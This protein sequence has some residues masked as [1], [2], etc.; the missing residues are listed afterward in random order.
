MFHDIKSYEARQMLM[1]Y[2]ANLDDFGAIAKQIWVMAHDSRAIDIGHEMEMIAHNCYK[3]AWQ[4]K[5]TFAR[6]HSC[7]R[8]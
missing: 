6:S 2:L 3:A 5:A 8:A 7:S 4:I 1:T